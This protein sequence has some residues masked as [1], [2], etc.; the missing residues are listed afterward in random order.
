MRA[1]AKPKQ[2]HLAGAASPRE[3]ACTFSFTKG[4]GPADRLVRLGHDSPLQDPQSDLQDMQADLLT[5]MIDA[6]ATSTLGP[7]KQQSGTR[8][9]RPGGPAAQAQ[10]AEDTQAQAPDRSPDIEKG[11]RGEG[12]KG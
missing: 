12:E 2:S 7:Y 9:S 8:P 6:A 4:H 1:G 3:L 10:R 5:P 11:R